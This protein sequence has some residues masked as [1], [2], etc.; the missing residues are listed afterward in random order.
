MGEIKRECRYC[1]APFE[2]EEGSS[3]HLPCCKECKPIHKL[4]LLLEDYCKQSQTPFR[5]MGIDD[6]T[7]AKLREIK[8]ILIVYRYLI[9]PCLAFMS[10]LYS[11]YPRGELEF[12]YLDRKEEGVLRLKDAHKI[13]FDRVYFFLKRAYGDERT[14]TSILSLKKFFSERDL[15]SLKLY[16]KEN[17]TEIS[18]KPFPVI[19]RLEKMTRV[20]QRGEAVAEEAKGWE[21]TLFLQAGEPL[22]SEKASFA[23]LSRA[24][25]GGFYIYLAFACALGENEMPSLE[26]N[27]RLLE[28]M[29]KMIVEKEPSDLFVF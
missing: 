18:V 28:T 11:S 17:K 19:K 23:R 1:S 16:V 7:K 3:F 12:L 22:P 29:D 8:E 5:V 2:E 6:E 15:S 25:I 21:E 26:I 10:S 4:A 24:S 9:H 20:L 27:P 13:L 14:E